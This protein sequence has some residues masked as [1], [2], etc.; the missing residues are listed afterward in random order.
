M[1]AE[2]LVR[3]LHGCPSVDAAMERCSKVLGDFGVEVS[4]AA[5][6]EVEALRKRTP[7]AGDDENRSQDALGGLQHKNRVLRRAVLFLAERCRRMEAGTQEAN[8]LRQALEQSQEVQRR[9]THANEVL[10]GHLKVHLDG[11]R[12]DPWMSGH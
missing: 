2:T 6:R 1:G 4:Q 9:L 8:A 12:S 3:M 5:L 10:Q 11:C 7:P